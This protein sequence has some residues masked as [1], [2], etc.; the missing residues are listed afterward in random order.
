MA[1]NDMGFKYLSH[2]QAESITPLLGGRDLLGAAQTGSGKT[3]AFLIPCRR[4]S[5]PVT[6]I[7]ADHIAAPIHSAASSS[8]LTVGV[9]L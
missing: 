5:L 6:A 3:L 1:L 8:A 2:I 7:I 4:C 9:Q